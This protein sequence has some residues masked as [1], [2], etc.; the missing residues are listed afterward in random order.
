MTRGP[1]VVGLHP[2]VAAPSVLANALALSERLE[3]KLL[4]VTSSDT[5][6]V[7]DSMRG[8]LAQVRPERLV[9][10]IVQNADPGELICAVAEEYKSPLI[11]IGSHGRRLPDLLLGTTAARI[12]EHAAGS[13]LVCRPWQQVQPQ[14]DELLVA[15]DGSPDSETVLSSAL[16]FCSSL[17]ARLTL[18]RAVVVPTVIS[19]DVLHKPEV[20][21]E[22]LLVGEAER[23]LTDLSRRLS[24]DVDCEQRVRVGSAWQTIVETAESEDSDLVV[25]GSHSHDLLGRLLGSTTSKVVNHAKRSTLVVKGGGIV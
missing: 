18:L 6:A 9:G 25:L 21:L 10:H 7:V 4:I 12:V 22:R 5:E 23:F 24:E 3:R 17:A 20:D 2:S 1:I 19:P 14:F 8:E 13:V 16:V 15:V 11:V